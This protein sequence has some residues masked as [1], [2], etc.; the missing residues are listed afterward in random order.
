MVKN[1]ALVLAAVLAGLAGACRK[2]ELTDGRYQGMVEYDRRDLAFELPGRVAQVAVTRGQELTA[3]AL[4]ARQDDAL[5]RESREIRVRDVAVAS[6]ELALVKAGARPED[7]RGAQAT[8][9]AAKAAELDA[10]K[11]LARLRGL[12][13]KGALPAAGL[14]ALEAQLAA[15]T[16]QRQAQEER[17]RALKNGA[18]AQEIDRAAAR[19]A[20]AAQALVAEDTKLTKRALIAPAAGIVEDVYIQPGEMASAGTPVIALIDALHPYADVFVPVAEVAQIHVGDTALLAVEGAPTEA[21]GVVE[22][23]Y[24]QAEFTPRFVFSPRERPNLM[25]RVRVR[26]DDRARALHAGLPA[27]AR[28]EPA[29]AIATAPVA[30]PDAPARDGG[31]R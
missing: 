25:M 31:A 22:L 11:E 16:G 14:D 28:F 29:A 13:A 17:L 1:E 24:A 19:V 3:G 7:I 5:D 12:V 8:L 23:V 26:L 9:T 21:R 6:A 10:Q 27:Y 15:A 4:I 20:Q 18:R 30:P 2:P